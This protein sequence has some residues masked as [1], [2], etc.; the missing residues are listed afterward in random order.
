MTNVRTPVFI[1]L[2]GSYQKTDASVQGRLQNI[3][4]S[5]VKATGAILTSS[6][7]GQP[8]LDVQQVSLS[9]IQ[10]TTEEP[11]TK[12]W[13]ALAIG[14]K[15]HNYSEATMFGRLPA[16]GFYARHVQGLKFENVSVHSG[17]GDPRPML[18]CDDVQALT[19]DRVSGTPGRDAEAFLDLRRV[20]TAIVEN[21]TA[22]SGVA[23]FV[24][25]SGE[26]T[27]NIRLMRNDVKGAKHP[28]QIAPEVRQDAVTEIP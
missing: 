1:R 18:V 4:I 20:Q 19:V 27:H 6:I 16:Y 9:S 26:A 21:N 3:N 22:P 23:A 11:G 28:L 2:Q 24:R 17:T 8:G 10:I 14:E 7:T 25:V 13:A 15:P 12:E 5:G